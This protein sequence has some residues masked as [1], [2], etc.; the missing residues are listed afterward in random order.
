MRT[1]TETTG[2]QIC[3]GEQRGGT[4]LQPGVFSRY[5]ALPGGQSASVAYHT[6]SQSVVF[7]EGDSAEV[8]WRIFQAGGQTAKARDYILQNGTFEGDP[9]SEAEA[10]LAGFVENLRTSSLLSPLLSEQ[11]DH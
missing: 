8:W 10:T 11:V 7:F 2:V 1:N 6:P 4:R 5:Y 3:T 9:E